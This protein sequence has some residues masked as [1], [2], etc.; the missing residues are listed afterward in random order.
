MD[1]DPRDAGLRLS[2]L[3][4]FPPEERRAGAA[5]LGFDASIVDLIGD[6]TIG[7]LKFPVESEEHELG[8]RV[9]DGAIVAGHVAAFRESQER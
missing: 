1:I 5:F 2:A 7:P 6:A 3:M 8:R 4:V 9:V